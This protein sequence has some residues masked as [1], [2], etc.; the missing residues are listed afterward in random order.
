VERGC[1]RERERSTFAPSSIHRRKKNYRRTSSKR[2]QRHGRPAD[3]NGLC[4][5]TSKRSRADVYQRLAGLTKKLVV[6]ARAMLNVA[7]EEP[8]HMQQEQGQ[9]ETDGDSARRAART[10]PAEELQRSFF[11]SRQFLWELLPKP[12][13]VPTVSSVRVCRESMQL[14]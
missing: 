11:I 9:S 12:G 14:R 10:T 8:E 4:V 13:H 2:C 1:G 5:P 7:P 3:L 6:S